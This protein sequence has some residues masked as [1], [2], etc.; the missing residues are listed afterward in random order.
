MKHSTSHAPAPL[1]WTLLFVFFASIQP[2][3]AQFIVHEVSGKVSIIRN[4]ASVTSK[5]GTE[6]E[7]NDKFKLEEGASISLL[8]KITNKIYSAT[9][10]GEMSISQIITRAMDRAKSHAS[11]VV[12]AMS[13]GKAAKPTTVYE[14]NG[15]VRRSQAVL[16][17]EAYSVTIEPASLANAILNAVKTDSTASSG[18]CLQVSHTENPLSFKAKST[19]DSPIY[20]NVIKLRT[21]SGKILSADI[22]ELGQPVNAYVLQPQQ[23]LMREQPSEDNPGELHILVATHFGYDID[24]LLDAMENII[25]SGASTLNSDPELTLYVFPLNRI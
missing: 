23:E 18:D 11:N 1:L 8:N 17:P 9:G 21:D 3:G 6:C 13:F 14:Q 19:S 20:L 22:S 7:R 12:G 16:D 15:M 4:G 5:S 24:S 25:D 10:P 2:V